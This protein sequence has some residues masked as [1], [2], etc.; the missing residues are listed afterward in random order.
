MAF[1]P[2]GRGSRA[3]PLA[4]WAVAGGLLAAAGCS[5]L[6]DGAL[7]D[8]PST[9][10]PTG[11]GGSGQGGG[12]VGGTGG[13]GGGAGAGAGGSPSCGDACLREECC[14]GVCQ[15]LTSPEHCGACDVACSGDG[16][17][18]PSG[19]AVLASDELNCGECGLECPGTVC[20]GGECTTTCQSPF[21]NCDQ[22]IVTNG[23]EANLG[24]DPQN[25]GSCG[26]RCPENATCEG[27]Q[28]VCPANF[29]DCDG[30][31]DNGCEVDS[32]NDPENCG[33]CTTHCGPNEACVLGSCGCVTGFDDCNGEV[34]DGCEASLSSVLHCG[35][36]NASCGDNGACASPQ[37]DCDCAPGFLDCDLALGCEASSTS[38]ATCGTCNN[39]C[40][41][42][43]VCD[44]TM[45]ATGC[46]GGLV[47]CGGACVDLLTDPSHCSGCN[48]PVGPN[49]SCVGGTPQCAPGFDDCTVALGCETPTDSDP[50]NCGG[51]GIACKSGAVCVQ[52]SCTCAAGTPK[53]CGADCRV[54]CGDADCSDGNGCTTDTCA[55]GGMSCTSSG[56]GGGTQCCSQTSCQAC[57]SD[58]DCPGQVCSGGV[59]IDGCQAPLVACG[60]ACV[61]LTGSDAHCG[62]CGNACVAGRSCS[63]SA[64]MPPWQPIGGAGAPVARQQAGSVWAGT[65]MFLWGGAG[66]TGALADGFFYD[67]ALNSWSAITTA[68]APSA[69]VLPGVAWTGSRA[70]VWGGG[71]TN[72]ES[73]LNTGGVYDPSTDS[74]QS[75][76][77]VGAPS[78]RRNP[79]ALWT[80]SRVLVWGGRNPGGAANGGG[81]YNVGADTWSAMSSGGAPTSRR[82]FA[83]AWSGTELY[84]FGGLQNGASG[85]AGDGFAYNPTT[86]EWRS[87]PSANAPSA[88]QSAVGAWAG[89]RF[90]VFGGV[91]ANGTTLASGARYNPT[92]DAWTAI[93][94]MPAARSAPMRETGFAVGAGDRVVLVGGR[95]A[96][97]A[98]L[99]TG[100]TYRPSLDAWSSIVA[101]PSGSDHLWAATA[102]SGTEI[103]LWGG[104]HGANAI[105]TGERLQP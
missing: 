67:P 53:D 46:S 81:L 45:C 89:G 92:T 95:N 29:L 96:S 75:T 30:N 71:P 9:S 44:G 78:S 48:N 26:L 16:A 8:K 21:E 98:A 35:A 43:D 50:Q 22:N 77:T 56:C 97:G 61:D 60:G 28:C 23:C 27:G 15:D 13:A 4:A 14:D 72:N 36:C 52:G 17:C 62:A 24:T 32:R 20:V 34:G 51:C 85:V 103:F 5:L 41:G 70:V 31:P 83:W 25:C 39:V 76:S 93:A 101:W 54:C 6:A 100:L 99:T 10:E 59:C 88:R 102:W 12:V 3:T 18:C 68:G 87:L 11:P 105:G 57:C 91:D 2:S 37:L 19:C 58:A 80:G 47:D 33:G 42:A 94:N 69:R 55:P 38:T 82:E 86:D 7:D 1:P 64:C 40:T 73:G 49:A 84:V 66:Q 63:S 79:V 104:L 65:R 74:W 90:V